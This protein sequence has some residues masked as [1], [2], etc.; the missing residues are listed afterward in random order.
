MP[1]IPSSAYLPMASEI[2][3]DA[4]SLIAEEI[5]AIIKR[6]FRVELDKP[7]YHDLR[8]KILRDALLSEIETILP[9]RAQVSFRIARKA[10]ERG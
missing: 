9:P 3:G 10:I 6:A 2:D 4:L 1:A 5:V 7:Y 8:D